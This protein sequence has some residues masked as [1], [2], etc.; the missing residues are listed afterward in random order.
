[1]FYTCVRRTIYIKRA[2]TGKLIIS[3]HRIGFTPYFPSFF[4]I[5]YLPVRF[6][7][8]FDVERVVFA[9]SFLGAELVFVAGGGL[10]SSSDPSGSSDVLLVPPLVSLVFVTSATLGLL[11]VLEGSA[12]D[13]VFILSFQPNR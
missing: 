10:K 2:A 8:F 11:S 1:M 13:P 9:G 3:T 6:L 5:P 12:A 4:Y 7:L